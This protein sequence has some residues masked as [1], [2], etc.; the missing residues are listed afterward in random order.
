MNEEKGQV[1]ERG[2]FK[3]IGIGTVHM[4]KGG[5][6]NDRISSAASLHHLPQT[7]KSSTPTVATACPAK[8]AAL[9]TLLC[10]RPSNLRTSRADS[11]STSSSSSSPLLP[12]CHLANF[13][14]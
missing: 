8:S 6:G 4:Q 12:S 7:N 14:A 2:K 1:G 13:G 10:T 3:S 9:L 5:G 11:S